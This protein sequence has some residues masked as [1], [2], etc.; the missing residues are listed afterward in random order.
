MRTA[1]S[2]LPREKG[3]GRCDGFFGICRKGDAATGAMRTAGDGDRLQRAKRRL[4]RS[5][6]RREIGVAMD[7]LCDVDGY[8]TREVTDRIERMGVGM[9]EGSGVTPKKSKSFLRQ[10]CK[11]LQTKR[12]QKKISI[13]GVRPLK[14]PP[15]T[16]G[17][18]PLSYPC[19]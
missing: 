12:L 4:S 16:I 8:G 14:L 10:N 7:T 11:Y 5:D 19:P 13:N 6:R 3:R 18:D 1:T 17:F 9:C 15:N 2:A